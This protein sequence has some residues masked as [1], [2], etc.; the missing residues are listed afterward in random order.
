MSANSK[1]SDGGAGGGVPRPL[2]GKYGVSLSIAVMA[3][4]PYIILTTAYELFRKQV[5]AEIG[6]DRQ[7]LQIISSMGTAGYAFGA[8]F[9][10][11]II[12][13]FHQRKLFLMTEAAFVAGCV[14]AA[15]AS[16]PLQFGIGTVIT[17]MTTGLMLV[18]ALPPVVR[19]FP[20]ERMPITTAVIDIGFFGAITLGPLIG[21]AVEFAHVWRWLYA[22]FG[23]VGCLIWITALFT[24][25]HNPPANPNQR[26]DFAAVALALGSTAL[27]FLAS[28]EL[29]R[30]NFDSYWFMVPL[31][32]GFA[33]LVAMLLTEFHSE[34][35]LAPVRPMWH[36]VPLAGTMIAMIGGGAYVTF[37]ELGEQFTIKVQHQTPL[38]VGLAFWPQIVGVLITSVL[39]GALIR[40]RLLPI[41]TL[42]GMVVLMGGGALLL[43][44]DP[45]RLSPVLLGSAAMLGLGAGATV[46]PALWLAGFSLP[47]KMVGRTFALVEL[48][49]S[50]ADFIMAPVLLQVA[51]VSSG[52]K[53]LTAAGIKSAIWITILITIATTGF[54]VLVYLAGGAG[55][56]RPDLKGWLKNNRTAVPSPPLGAALKKSAKRQV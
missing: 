17:G 26:F 45:H 39:L 6:I 8:L 30:H 31:A 22:G 49:R 19:G 50:E 16:G 52:G 54:I 15:T 1:V 10:G 11:D 9:G 43:Y 46:S 53:E 4:V 7:G 12:Q 36:T 13:R 20:P 34:E 55:L 42:A 28:A 18:I 44:M 21:G 37:L 48:V 29:T 41:F 2:E 23:G 27:P 56:P 24:L 47:S 3:L 35:P 5:G 40:T 51:L 38:A 25:P 33:C 32:I 14:L